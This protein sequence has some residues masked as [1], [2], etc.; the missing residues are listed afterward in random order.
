[1]G[2]SLRNYGVILIENYLKKEGVINGL[3]IIPANVAGRVFCLSAKREC[4]F[5]KTKV[6]NVSKHSMANVLRKAM[7]IMRE[8]FW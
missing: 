4:E 5:Q 7:S 6:K 3:C 2:L 8:Y 1:M